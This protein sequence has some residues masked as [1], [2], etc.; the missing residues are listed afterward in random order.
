MRIAILSLESVLVAGVAHA[1]QIENPAYKVWSQYNPGTTVHIDGT[2][3]AKGQSSKMTLVTTLKSKTDDKLVIEVKT[4]MTVMGHDMDMP[5]QTHEITKT[6]DKA[7]LAPNMPSAEQIAKAE[8]ET[9]TVPAGTFK[10][11]KLE[12]HRTQNGM[13]LDGTT[14]YS[15]EVPGGT[16]KVV[17]T[18]SGAVTSITKMELQSVEKK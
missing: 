17:M 16:V 1:E 5:P 7:Q 4:K 12:V 6:I 13:K 9:V 18:G 10:C 8:E 15:E 14:Y 11:K 2:T 3:E